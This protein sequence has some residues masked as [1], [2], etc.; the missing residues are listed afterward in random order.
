[1]LLQNVLFRS[2]GAAIALTNRRSAHAQGAT[3][4][5][6]CHTQRTHLGS[7]DQAYYSVFQQEDDVGHRGVR[8][9]KNLMSIA[10]QGLKKHMTKLA[11]HILP[12]SELVSHTLS[13]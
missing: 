6:L 9:D 2:G 8:L 10:A 11:P 1:M 12:P 4:Y 13:H 3:K 5:Q 7:S